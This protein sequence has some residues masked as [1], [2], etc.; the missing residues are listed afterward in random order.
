MPH[1]GRFELLSALTSSQLAPLGK[2]VSGTG[3]FSRLGVR[4]RLLLAFFGISAFAV[5]GAEVAL[6][7]FRQIGDAF[8]TV[9]QR[10]VPVALMA[11]ELSRHAERIVAAA[12][13]LLT[14]AT[15]DEKTERSAAISAE[16]NV[17]YSLLSNL[18]YAGV[19]SQEL[20]ELE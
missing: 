4:G 10:R 1:E 16:V 2:R 3:F 8:A 7:S 17:L 20:E 15:R 14:V 18:R 13:A 6:Y 12:P 19:E 9:T 11:Q 5:L